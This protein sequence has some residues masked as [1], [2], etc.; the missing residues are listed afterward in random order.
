[1]KKTLLAAVLL[2]LTCVSSFA[3]EATVEEGPSYTIFTK[4][5]RGIGN[6]ILSPFEIP[7]SIVH[8]AAD[9][10]VFVGA[11]AGT[12]GGLAGGIERLCAGGVEMATFLFPPYD[13]ALINY[14]LGKSPAA[15]AAS[16]AFPKPDEF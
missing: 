3:Q 6:V 1:M 7:V 16:S 12:I 15:Q 11:T 13:R 4:L 8:V 2:A 10:D 9:T 5:G 14:E